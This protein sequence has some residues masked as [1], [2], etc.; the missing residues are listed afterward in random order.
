MSSEK[1][2][3]PT[4]TI[5]LKRDCDATLIPY[6]NRVTLR[7]GEDVRITQALGGNF[8]VLIRG[9]LV[10]IEGKDADSLGLESPP[11]KEVEKTGQNGGVANEQAVWDVMKTCYDP[12]IPVN[13]VDLGLIYSCEFD[14]G[15]EEGSKVQVKMTLTAPGCGMGGPLSEEVKQKILGVPGV[16]EVG[17]ELV[18]DPPWNR[19]MMSDGAKLQLGML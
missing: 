17:V 2:D 13:I 14:H 16:S 11:E 10:R 9:N 7:A 4:G 5:A 19:E 3:R 15:E 6:G 1:L 12:E 18:W 8:T